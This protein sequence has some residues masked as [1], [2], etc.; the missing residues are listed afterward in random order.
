MTRSCNTIHL[1]LVPNNFARSL[2]KVTGQ[3]ILVNNKKGKG[4][5]TGQ[6]KLPADRMI[7]DVKGYEKS[8]TLIR[9]AFYSLRERGMITCI[10]AGM[11]ILET[12]DQSSY[13]L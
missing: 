1:G 4:S 3:G 13:S 6:V 10:K 8:P 2:K 9:M 12:H 7:T 5:T 11:G